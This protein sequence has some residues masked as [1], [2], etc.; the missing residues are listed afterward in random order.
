MLNIRNILEV[1]PQCLFP[2]IVLIALILVL[3]IFSQL[4]LPPLIGRTAIE[5]HEFMCSS[6]IQACTYLHTLGKTAERRGQLERGAIFRLRNLS[7]NPLIVISDYRLAR[8]A[9]EGFSESCDSTC[10][11]EKSTVKQFLLFA[12]IRPLV[13]YVRT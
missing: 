7:L 9:F 3:R 11:T 10:E 12:D 13:W 4:D 2:A 1:L 6:G 8:R 5:N